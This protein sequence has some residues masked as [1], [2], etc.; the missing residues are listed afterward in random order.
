MTRALPVPLRMSFPRSGNFSCS[1]PIGVHQWWI[2]TGSRASLFWLCLP[3][4]GIAKRLMPCFLRE[5]SRRLEQFSA[6]M[7]KEQLSSGKPLIQWPNV[8]T[9]RECTTHLR[10]CWRTKLVQLH[11]HR[12]VHIQFKEF[13]NSGLRMVW[14]HFPLAFCCFIFGPCYSARISEMDLENARPSIF[15]PVQIR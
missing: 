5:D 7:A 11:S 10:A 9:L 13:P 4:A 12:P 1:C 2:F 8:L 14:D 3:K 6:L 15:L